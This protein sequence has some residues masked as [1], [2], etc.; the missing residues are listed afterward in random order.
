MPAVGRRMPERGIEAR[1]LD[2]DGI[3]MPDVPVVVEHRVLGIE[4]D[5]AL[6][7]HAPVGPSPVAVNGP[8]AADT[9]TRGNRNSHCWFEG[10]FRLC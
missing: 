10:V 9:G 4:H 8:G 7:I 2:D 1:S 3:L 5:D 6:H